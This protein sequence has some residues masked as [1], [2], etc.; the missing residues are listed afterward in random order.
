ML[1]L[2]IMKSLYAHICVLH[3][4][5]SWL[6]PGDLSSVETNGFWNTQSS[7]VILNW[8]THC[9]NSIVRPC[10]PGIWEW[11]CH[12]ILIYT[13]TMAFCTQYF[14]IQYLPEKLTPWTISKMIKMNLLLHTLEFHIRHIILITMVEVS[15]GM[16]TLPANVSI[17]LCGYCALGCHNNHGMWA[18]HLVMV[19]TQ[20]CIASDEKWCIVYMT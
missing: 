17:Y 8:N 12:F 1:L 16:L 18:I 19:A 14:V 6:Q 4:I 9:G 5:V 20:I 10:M 7:R 15:P 2:S 13:L 3:S 11:L